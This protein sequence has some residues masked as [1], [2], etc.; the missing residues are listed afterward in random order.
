MK[1]L[2]ICCD[3]TW[4]KISSPYPTNVVKITQA[5]SDRSQLVFYSEGIGTGNWIDRIAGGILGWGIDKNIQDAYRFLC[6][7]YAP[8]DRIF[9]FGFSRGAYTVRSLVGLIRSVGIL[10]R[11]GIRLIP[12]AYQIYQAAKGEFVDRDT[13]TREQVKIRELDRVVKFRQEMTDRFGADYQ[14]IAEITLLSCWDTVGALGIPRLMWMPAFI[15]RLLYKKYQFHNTKL[16]S[17]I[18]HALHAIAIDENRKAFSPTPMQAA[19]PGQVTEVWFPGGHGCVGGGTR[20]N[21][22]FSNAALLWTID[23]VEQL[24]L[25]LKFD[26]RKI[27]DGIAT[28]PTAEIESSWQLPVGKSWRQVPLDATFD[29]SVFTRWQAC[30]WYR[31]QNLVATHQHLLNNFC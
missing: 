5:L 11:Q 17:K 23:T 18:A 28:K 4:Q 21:S 9:L 22:G 1:Q 31:P 6:L 2:I 8:G 14:E 3:G 7:N 15:D 19:Q 10:P 16:S 20:A 30:K 24:D 26:R 29:V 27:E 12:S 13:A 25:G